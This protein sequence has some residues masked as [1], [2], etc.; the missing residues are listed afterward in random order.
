MVR[1]MEVVN[2]E[3]KRL[4]IVWPICVACWGEERERR[5]RGGVRGG[6]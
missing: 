1:E 4:V 6:E 3:V 5:R 2:E